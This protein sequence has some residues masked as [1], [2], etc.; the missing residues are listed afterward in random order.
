M[1]SKA[2]T[3]ISHFAVMKLLRNACYISIFLDAIDFKLLLQL[4]KVTSTAAVQI[5][6][7]ALGRTN[8]AEAYNA[9]AQ[10]VRDV[11]VASQHYDV[12]RDFAKAANISGDDVTISEVFN[13]D[14]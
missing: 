3:S 4:H 13:I 6:Y 10:R 5:N 9:E 8:N 2:V 7:I 11:L 1:I 14:M 12:A